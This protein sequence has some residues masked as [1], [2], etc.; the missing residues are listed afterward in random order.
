M[1][2]NILRKAGAIKHDLGNPC[3][4]GYPSPVLENRW[5]SDAT[6]DF[7]TRNPETGLSFSQII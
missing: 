1:K 6:G 4:G 2:C 3:S 7:K 5:R